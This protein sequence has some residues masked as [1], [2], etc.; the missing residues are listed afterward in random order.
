MVKWR[1]IMTAWTDHRS[2]SESVFSK[3]QVPPKQTSPRTPKEYQHGKE[4]QGGTNKPNPYL[5][6]DS[7]NQG[8]LKGT[9]QGVCDILIRQFQGFRQFLL[10][11]DFR[12][13]LVFQHKP[14]WEAFASQRIFFFG[15]S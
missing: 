13:K 14:C 3:P 6:M 10:S 1:L 15:F 2:E 7:G 12:S 4:S 5:S 9:V 11:K 8:H